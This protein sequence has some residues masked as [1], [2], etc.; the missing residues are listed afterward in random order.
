MKNKLMVSFA[1][2]MLPI[3][4]FAATDI[5]PDLSKISSGSVYES[6]GEKMCNAEVE[7][8]YKSDGEKEVNVTFISMDD[9]YCRY[10]G[11]VMTFKYKKLWNIYESRE[12]VEL[13]PLSDGN[14]VLRDMQFIGDRPN[15]IKT[16]D[17]KFIRKSF[18]K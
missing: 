15:T 9:F 14:F 2:I 11:K 17:V 4:S 16:E 10:S 8:N 7:V 5:K 1:T 6:L 18:L 12:M 3:L 13:D